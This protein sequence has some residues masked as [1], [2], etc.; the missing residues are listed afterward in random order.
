MTKTNQ[1]T[2]DDDLQTVILKT[3]H[4]HAGQLYLAGETLRVNAAMREW[5]LQQGV[6]EL[7][8]PEPEILN[9]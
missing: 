8:D 3:Q 2:M 7:N 4:M 5:L 9:F 6:I 1:Q